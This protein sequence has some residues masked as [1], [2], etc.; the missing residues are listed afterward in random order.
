MHR[1]LWVAALLLSG[2]LSQFEAQPIL[3]ETR[4]W[5]IDACAFVI[6]N[7]PADAA[8]LA[9]RLPAGFPL[10]NAPFAASP[11]GPR[12]DVARDA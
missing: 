11:V 4:P 8:K 12:A 6:V 5:G 1:T 2:C 7:I 3:P 10:G 9:A